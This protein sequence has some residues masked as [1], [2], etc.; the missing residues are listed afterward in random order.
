MQEPILQEDMSRYVMFPV[1]YPDIWDFYKRHS[2]TLWTA[3]EL[4]FVDDRREWKSK[5]SEND[6]YFIS[7]VLA[8][9]AASDSIVNENLATNF[10]NEVQYPEAK[11]FYGIQIYME[12]VHSESY[13]LM[14]DSLIDD[15]AEKS[16][17]F[18]GMTTVPCVGR[19]A[20]WALKWIKSDSF[21][22]RL[23]AFA[24]VEMIF[25]AGSFCSIFFLRER[26]VMKGLTHANDF[27][28]RDETLHGDFACHLY[29]NYVVNKLD[30]ERVKEI[31]LDAL[32]IEKEFIS[33]A[34]PVD[35]IGMNAGLMKQYLEFVTDRLLVSLGYSKH[36]KTENP[37][38]FMERI[39]L[40]GKDNF[41]EKRV[42]EYNKASVV[43]K[44]TDTSNNFLDADF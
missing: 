22:E 35:L 21:V 42:A 34:L 20:N 27:I 7:R 43:N 24:A 12:T 28:S 10:M 13:S 33:D 15:D 39:A 14:I 36:F 26:G 9:F 25:F 37:F 23:V 8:F 6:R 40:P 1:K 5:L 38:P 4:D 44:I 31:L 17:L 16:I 3:E 32:D 29:K 30:V 41:F 19:K 11:A 2:A 18:N